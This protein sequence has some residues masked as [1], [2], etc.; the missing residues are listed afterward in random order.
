MLQS[1]QQPCVRLKVPLVPQQRYHQEEQKPAGSLQKHIKR[2][3]RTMRKEYNQAKYQMPPKL[4]NIDWFSI[5]S[6]NG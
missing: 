5:K 4:V 1:V 2:I 6:Y 3:R